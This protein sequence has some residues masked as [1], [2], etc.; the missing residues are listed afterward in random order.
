MSKCVILKMNVFRHLLFW[1]MLVILYVLDAFLN[2]QRI[3]WV[4]MLINYLIFACVFYFYSL[5]I[6]PRVWSVKRNILFISIFLFFGAVFIFL[7]YLDLM[8]LE[9]WLYGMKKKAI[10][11][12]NFSIEV[13]YYYLQYFFFG[14]FYYRARSISFQK[15]IIAVAEREE[16]K[17]EEENLKLENDFLRAQVNPHFLFNCLNYLRETANSFRS[18]KL[19]LGLEI[20]SKIMRYSLKQPGD[21]G[22]VELEEEVAH[23]E[24]LFEMY[25]F[26]YGA[27]LYAEFEKK[28]NTEE[29]RIVPHVLITL[30]ENA[31]KH[32]Q[33][34]NPS[35]PIKVRLDIVGNR[36]EMTTSN[37]IQKTGTEMG[38]GA[39]LE[40][41]KKR[42]EHAYPG[43][44]K[45]EIS[46]IEKLFYTSLSVF[47]SS[48]PDAK[49]RLA[50]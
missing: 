46:T 45:L 20:L 49:I 22:Q 9:P 7:F 47:L 28:G 40:N 13:F 33:L 29:L 43:N 1:L 15:S 17:R 44:F 8:I 41:V 23:I 38:L 26:R 19:S 31:F 6:F 32:G 16:F 18:R 2:N 36:L 21:D 25:R 34:H 42:L 37:S 24:K 11:I 10:G 48:L 30:V 4:S 27:E 35:E 5:L 14:L 12:L 39:G 50:E 3:L